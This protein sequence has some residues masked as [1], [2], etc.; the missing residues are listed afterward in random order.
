MTREQI[1]EDAKTIKETS[2]FKLDWKLKEIS[3]N[4]ETKTSAA[5]FYGDQEE[6]SYQYIRVYPGADRPLDFLF[7]RQEGT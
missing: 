2:M 1:I 5:M 6:R 3:H 7:V 4:P